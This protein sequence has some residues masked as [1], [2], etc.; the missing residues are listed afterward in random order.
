MSFE[1][2]QKINA[3]AKNNGCEVMYK[4]CDN[5][6]EVWALPKRGKSILLLVVEKEVA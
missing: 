1:T 3:Y 4:D 5:C 6:I 2:R